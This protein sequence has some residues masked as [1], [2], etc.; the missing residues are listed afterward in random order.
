[1]SHVFSLGEVVSL[2]LVR[3]GLGLDHPGGTTWNQNSEITGFLF[4]I[5]Q[6]SGSCM[7]RNDC[8]YYVY[9][10]SFLKA[11]SRYINWKH[12]KY[13]PY[14]LLCWVDQL[15]GNAHLLWTL[16]SRQSWALVF[17]EPG[18]IVSGWPGEFKAYISNRIKPMENSNRSSPFQP[19]LVCLTGLRTHFYTQRCWKELC[20]DS[21]ALPGEN[22]QWAFTSVWWHA[23]KVVVTFSILCA[24][25]CLCMLWV[26]Q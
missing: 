15:N 3:V 1:M 18:C 23:E 13:F 22:R 19:P 6:C 24:S 9:N 2:V 16:K 21:C 14:F 8:M 4:T 12:G 11:R 10:P 7:I 26:S 25:V 20:C 17:Y 5:H